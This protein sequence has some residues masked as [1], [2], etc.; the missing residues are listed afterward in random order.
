GAADIIRPAMDRPLRVLI[1]GG[2]IGGLTT[3]IALRRAGHEP[4]VFEQ[5]PELREIGAGPTLWSNA[6]R[7]LDQLGLG[8]APP[9]PAPPPLPRRPAPLRRLHL[10]ARRVH[11][12]PGRPAR[13]RNIRTRRAVRHGP[14]EPLANLLVRHAKRPRRQDRPAG[15]RQGRAPL[16]V[17][18]MAR[19][20]P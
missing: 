10:L 4:V 20:D 14:A 9:A 17:Q 19:A 7:A 11:V 15:G 12:P 13:R 8:Q 1:I 6:V 3:A 18:G 16:P 2:G 5:A